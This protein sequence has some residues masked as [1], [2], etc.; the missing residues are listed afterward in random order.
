MWIMRLIKILIHSY[1]QVFKV[2][3]KAHKSYYN[4]LSTV[5]FV[6][7]QMVIHMLQIWLWKTQKA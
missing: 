4:R 1:P 3:N 7:K 6:V 5:R 2:I